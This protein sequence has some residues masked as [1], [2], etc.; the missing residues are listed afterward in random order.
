MSG[1][2]A[3]A[4]M[5][6]LGLPAAANAEG[7]RIVFDC[8]GADGT[9]TRFVVAPV[10]T[11]ATGK[12]PIRVIFSGKTYDGVAASNRGPFQFGTEAEHFALLIEGE[13]DGGG[14]K[15]QLHHATA[16]ASTLT[17]FTCETDI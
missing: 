1:F 15:A 8:T 11:D 14:L 2:A 12:G 16:T 4:L 6:G 5:L 17:P 9:I 7:A 10:E 3:V 13:A